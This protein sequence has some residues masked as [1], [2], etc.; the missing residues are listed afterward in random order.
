[1]RAARHLAHI[2]SGGREAPGRGPGGTQPSIR[3]ARWRVC[4]YA[5]RGARRPAISGT[6]NPGGRFWGTITNPFPH[7]A[8]GL[9]GDA[10]G[11]AG[12]GG[13]GPPGRPG[14][15]A[16]H[17]TPANNVVP[18][19]G[20]PGTGRRHTGIAGKDCPPDGCVL[21]TAQVKRPRFFGGTVET[22]FGTR[23]A[24]PRTLDAG[25]R[26]EGRYADIRRPLVTGPDRTGIVAAASS[27]LFCSGANIT[28]LPQYSTGQSGGTFFLRIE[29]QLADP[30]EGSAN[31]A[32]AFGELAG[33][34][35][36]RWKMTRAI[37]FT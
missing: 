17:S 21:P 13:R 25:R 20:A 27:F 29:V 9:P 8:P 16:G 22:D 31:R 30:A 28:D 26:A 19:P 12:P 18:A 15:V 10:G 7:A 11:A 3:H 2:G 23:S 34:F 37:V 14:F 1:M 33:R 5:T 24:G 32:S 35:P 6:P 36:M 4:P